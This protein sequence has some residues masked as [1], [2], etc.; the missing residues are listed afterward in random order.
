M[1]KRILPLIV[2]VLLSGLSYFVYHNPPQAQRMPPQR[3]PAISVEIET[4]VPRPYPIWIESYGRIRPRTQS[5]LLPQVAGEVVWIDPAFRVG[6][7]FEAGDELLRIDDRDYRVALAQAEAS[8]MA[9]RQTLSEEQARSEQARADWRRLGNSGEP[10]ALVARS[11]QLN[12][13]RA[14]LASAEAEVTQA[15]LNLER[16]RIRAP[17]AGRVLEK[18]VDIGQVV[19]SG[20]TLATLYAV[21]Y[22]E[23]RLPLQS[24]DL[25]Y[26]D[27]PERYRYS[28]PSEQAMPAVTLISDLIRHEEWQGRVVQTEGAIDDESRQLYVLAQLDDPYG[29]QA[30][31]RVPLKIGQYVKARI[32]GQV[33][34]HAIVVP[35]RVI[36]QGSYVYVEENGSVQRREVEIGWQN[37]EE[38]LIVAGLAPGDHLVTTTLGQV[39]SGTPVH[40][41]GQ[42]SEVDPPVGTGERPAATPPGAARTQGGEA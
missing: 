39:V 3:D 16:T 9:A 13:A 25:A 22:V 10:P 40:V 21:D 38:A 42:V 18:S 23:I 28:D 14:A 36:Y 27:L 35:N 24:R 8:L 33:L 17:Y 11:P 6:G 34:P 26:I 41:Q 29:A 30:E 19:S 12:A 1:M 2:I 4:I 31:G 37:E 20:T 32:E 7:F 15:K 5:E